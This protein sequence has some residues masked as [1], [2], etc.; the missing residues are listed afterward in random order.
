MAQST[1]SSKWIRARTISEDFT[2]T[3][4]GKYQRGS[5]TNLPLHNHAQPLYRHSAYHLR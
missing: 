1:V 5:E 2:L 4:L 3:T